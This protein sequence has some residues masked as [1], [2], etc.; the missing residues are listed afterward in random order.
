[1]ERSRGARRFG[2]Y[3]AQAVH[4]QAKICKGLALII[5]LACL[6]KK[7]SLVRQAFC[8]GQRT[9]SFLCVEDCTCCAQDTYPC[10]TMQAA[11]VQRE[12]QRTACFQTVDCHRCVISE[13]ALN[14]L[15]WIQQC[16]L[17]RRTGAT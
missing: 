13:P 15:P 16:V 17:R 1:M 11:E 8:D 4:R 6:D 3:C 14:R 2:N 5:A 7:R 10:Q 12:G 9:Q